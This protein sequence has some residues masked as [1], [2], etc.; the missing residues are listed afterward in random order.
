MNTI[1]Y[2]EEELLEQKEKTEFLIELCK[3]Y[4]NKNKLYYNI[5]L[6]EDIIR[7]HDNEIGYDKYNDINSL[8]FYEEELD[9]YKHVA[10]HYNNNDFIITDY[11]LYGGLYDAEQLEKFY[12]SPEAR[13]RIHEIC[14]E[15]EES[16]KTLKEQ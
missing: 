8:K 13:R 16:I 9:Y 6:P 5:P 10:E 3:K 11:H 14:D 2:R 4:R 1:D 12:I 7:K 15:I